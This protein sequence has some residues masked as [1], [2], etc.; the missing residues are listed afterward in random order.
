MDAANAALKNK[1]DKEMNQKYTDVNSRI[2]DQWVSD[3]WEWGKP[4]D[5]E[6][7]K[8]A[9]ENNWS[10]F[11]TPTK[12][13]PKEWFCSFAGARILGLASGGGQQMPIFAAL[14]A[15]CTV[16]DYS[17]AQLANE[18]MVAER[19]KYNI[20]IIKADMTKPLPFADSS[21]DLIFH[22]VS[23]CYIQDVIPVWKECFRVLRQNGLLLAGLDNGINYVFDINEKEVTNVLPFNPL[24]NKKLYEQSIKDNIGIQFSHTIE[25]QIGGQLKAGFTLVDIYHDTNGEGNL[26]IHN[27]PSYY[28]TCAMKK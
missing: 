3:G 23:N 8:K 19:E 26:H 6:T 4:I 7:F 10:V 15:V 17:D 18:K 14:G 13:V 11:L 20:E 5:H 16:L 9:K 21:F 22:P 25:E 2:I 12:A 27:I 24:T 1:Q 28:A